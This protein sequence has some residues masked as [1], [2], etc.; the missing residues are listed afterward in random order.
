MKLCTGS[1]NL[2]CRSAA[3]RSILVYFRPQKILARQKQ[4]RRRRYH[5]EKGGAPET[6]KIRRSRN[7]E[8]EREPGRMMDR[9]DY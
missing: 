7:Q 2:M 5:T 6:R 1:K 8:E 4:K 3:R 9:F